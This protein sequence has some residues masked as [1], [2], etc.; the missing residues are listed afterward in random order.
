[1]RRREG[2]LGPWKLAI[3]DEQIRLTGEQV[4]TLEECLRGYV[5]EVNVL[6]RGGETLP[7]YAD[8]FA[9]RSWGAPSFVVRFDMAPMASDA[10]AGIYEIEGNPAGFSFLDLVGIP[11]GEILGGALMRLGVRSIA[12]TVAPSRADQATDHQRL[13]ELIA[14]SG[15]TV[16]S[17][18]H[19]RTDLNGTP[20]WM[21]AGE[22]DHSTVG[23]LEEKSLLLFR[24]GG[25]HKIYLLKLGGGRLLSEFEN[26]AAVMAAYP[27]GLVMKPWRSWGTKEVYC[28][29]PHGPFRH[30]GVSTGHIEKQLERA[31]DRN[32]QGRFVIQPFYPP[33]LRSDKEDGKT[34][35]RIW[36]VFAVW[37]PDGYKVIG[38]VWNERPSTLRIHGASDALWGP[39]HAP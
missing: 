36:R 26:V 14:A 7:R 15:I 8:N 35:C 17:V 3:G 31:F 23:H 16:E 9:M 33:A 5:R 11:V 13:M 39:I 24:D 4:A 25:G 6:Y 1:M 2:R 22:E 28:Y 32:E 34:Y 30:I 10:T 21:R 18:A 27:N 12:S 20:V 38:G 19:T 37:T 29:D